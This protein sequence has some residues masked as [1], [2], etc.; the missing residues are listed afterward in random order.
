MD[1][2]CLPKAYN[3]MSAFIKNT[4]FF[5]GW[6]LSPLTFWN[7]VFVNIPISYFCASL[8]IRFI[9]A[10]FLFLVLVFYW[11]S[12]GIGILMM[13]FSGKSIM[14]DK[15]NRL[16]ALKTFLITVI[17]YSIIIVILSKIGVLKPI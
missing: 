6:M 7:D 17:I 16:N 15:S 2:L 9:R 4:V 8:A 5:I 10:D 3:S 11:L 14:R 1:T 13:F 12:N